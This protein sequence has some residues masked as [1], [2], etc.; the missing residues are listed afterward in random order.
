MMRLLQRVLFVLLLL[1]SH[2]IATAGLLHRG[3]AL[4]GKAIIN[5]GGADFFPG[6]FINVFKTAS[7]GPS[8]VADFALMD[9]QGYFVGTLASNSGFSF[10]SG[11]TWSGVQYKIT[12]TADIQTKI[13]FN[14]IFTSC[15]VLSG[16][17]TISGCSGG[18]STF[19]I[20]AG[21]AGAISFT[22]TQTSFSGFFVG[23]FTFAHTAGGSLSMYRTSDEAAFLAGQIYTPEFVSVLSALRPR[24]IRTMGF[25][26]ENNSQN[27][28]TQWRYRITPQDFN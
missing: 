5:I 16:N 4:S 9:S 3:G 13:T 23:G 8:N 10:N 7:V 6:N 15:T 25:M 11:I 18:T 22:T 28:E 12:W 21:Q 27:G 14:S 20:T 26:I 1:A 19:T 24:A 2:S 17:A